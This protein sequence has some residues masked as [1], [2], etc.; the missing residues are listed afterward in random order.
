M[1]TV[2]RRF[3]TTAARNMEG[4]LVVGSGLTGLAIAKT[5]KQKNAANRVRFLDQSSKSPSYSLTLLDSTIK[6]LESAWSCPGALSKT[7]VDAQLGRDGSIEQRYV[8]GQGEAVDGPG[9]AGSSKR[10]SREA[11]DQFLKEGISIEYDKKVDKV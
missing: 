3:L 10:I 2:T 4:L 9:Q 1:S 7:A 5:L 6:T 8:D 11:L